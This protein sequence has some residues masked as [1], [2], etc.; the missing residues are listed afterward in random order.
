MIPGICRIKENTLHHVWKHTPWSSYNYTQTGFSHW[1]AFIE[2]SSLYNDECFKNDFCILYLY[3]TAMPKMMTRSEISHSELRW[4][5]CAVSSVESGVMW[6][7]IKSVPF[8]ERTSQQN[9]P[10]VSNFF[11]FCGL[12]SL[13]F[14][15]CS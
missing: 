3:F 13:D 15:I 4:E 14:S 7:L 8:M 10:S 11:F 9:L 5:M 1:S 2:K 6:T 12:Q